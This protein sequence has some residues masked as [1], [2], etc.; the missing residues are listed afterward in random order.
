[1]YIDIFF[2][3]YFTTYNISLFPVQFYTWYPILILL[4]ININKFFARHYSRFSHYLFLMYYLWIRTCFYDVVITF[5]FDKYKPFIEND[6]MP[7][8]SISI[9]LCINLKCIIPYFYV[10]GMSTRSFTWIS[11]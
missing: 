7:I 10:F 11:I 1:M 8:S 6:L 5:I 4:P 3:L 9:P 2:R